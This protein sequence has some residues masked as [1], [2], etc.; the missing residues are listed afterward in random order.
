MR[1]RKYYFLFMQVFFSITV[2]AGINRKE[3]VQIGDRTGPREKSVF[4]Q[5]LLRVHSRFVLSRCSD[6]ATETACN[7]QSIGE[8]TFPRW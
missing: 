4:Q 1:F 6:P 5:S 8:N 2:L 3:G 7:T